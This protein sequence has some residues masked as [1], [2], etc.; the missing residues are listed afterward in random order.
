MAM[1]SV[2]ARLYE[3]S[4]LPETHAT[5]FAGRAFSA[6]SAAGAS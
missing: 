6:V 1:A 4:T 2:T 3:P 5:E